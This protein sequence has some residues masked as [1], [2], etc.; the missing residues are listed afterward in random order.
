MQLYFPSWRDVPPQQWPWPNFSPYEIAVKDRP[1]RGAVLINPTAMNCLQRMRTIL[2][3]PVRITSAYRDPIYNARV[4]GAEQ[5]KHIM[6][7]A[8]D[9]A[10]STS[11]SRDDLVAAARAAGFRGFGHYS[12]FLHI[13]L[14]NE[15]E[16]NG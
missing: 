7:I 2:N 3:A 13:D 10:P 6:G 4:G 11:Y 5:S 9:I 12:A 15:R 8:F 14:G 1:E 16:W